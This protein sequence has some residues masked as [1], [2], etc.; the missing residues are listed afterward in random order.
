LAAIRLPYDVRL[1]HSDVHNVSTEERRCA[2]VDTEE[3]LPV[4]FLESEQY[5][6]V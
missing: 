5:H 3:A 6:R 4:I 1:V 2:F